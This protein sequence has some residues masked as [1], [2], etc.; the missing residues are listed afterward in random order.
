VTLKEAL[1]VAA[2]AGLGV[3]PDATIPNA[4]IDNTDLIDM[5]LPPYPER[6]LLRLLSADPGRTS[7]GAQSFALFSPVPEVFL[8]PRGRRPVAWNPG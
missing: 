2:E 7:E 3:K 4:K 1:A 8:P 6:L 5:A